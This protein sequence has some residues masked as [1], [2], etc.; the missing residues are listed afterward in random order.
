MPPNVRPGGGPD[1]H[2]EF[3]N[4]FTSRQQP[5]SI[6]QRPAPLSAEEHAAHRKQLED[7]EFVQPK[8][9]D[10]H[11]INLTGIFGKWK[12]YCTEKQ[13]GEWEATLRNVSRELAMDFFL[14]VCESYNVRS[15]GSSKVYIRQFQE[16]YTTITG[17]FMNRNH[18]R[19][20]YHYHD[21]VLIP[22]FRLRPPN[23]DGKPVLSAAELEI[24]VAFNIAYDTST[25]P[26]EW[27]RI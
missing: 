3:L 22:Q 6:S 9:S 5:N 15:W 18:A 20:L 19:D 8:F 14:F 21:R 11:K 2:R 26:S 17:K 24:I 13:V 4:R 7:T 25:F 12:R 27:Q 23:I 10:E 16:M 1:G